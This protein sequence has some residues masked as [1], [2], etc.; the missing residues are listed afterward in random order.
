MIYDRRLKR[1]LLTEEDG[2]VIPERN[3][4]QIEG[5]VYC[6]KPIDENYRLS[7]GGN[8]SVYIIYDPDNQEVDKAIKISNIAEIN[9]KSPE[10]IK[11]RY[12]RFMNEIDALNQVK[13]ETIGNNVVRIEKDGMLEIDGYNYPYYIM[14]KADSDLG[15]YLLSNPLA[16]DEQERVKLCIDIFNG[17]SSLHNLNFYHRDIKP[18][19]VLLFFQDVDGEDVDARKFIWKIGDL[20]LCQHRDKDYDDIGEKIGPIGWLS[21]EAMN[22]YLTEKYALGLDCA[23]SEESDLFQLGKVFWFIFQNNVPIGQIVASDF[24]SQV[25][26]KDFIYDIISRMLQYPKSRRMSKLDLNYSLQL[27]AQEFGV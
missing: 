17:V 10:W 9:R 20:G 12:G 22:K 23:I 18:D 19:N 15:S 3:Q 16:L 13:D 6:L 27:L 5:K 4:L 8:S 2:L 21:P 14:E 11:R 26:N 24:N 7:K 1:V 25:R